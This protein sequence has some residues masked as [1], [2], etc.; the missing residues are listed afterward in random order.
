MTV[1]LMF[2][3]SLS[4]NDDTLP[5]H[6]NFATYQESRPLISGSD[7]FVSS[8]LKGKRR[9]LYS[10]LSYLKDQLPEFRSKKLY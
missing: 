7:D 3:L 1:P 5:Q 8:F 2:L 9:S 4:A 6:A 10:A